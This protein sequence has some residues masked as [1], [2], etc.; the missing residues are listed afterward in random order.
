M[1]SILPVV[2]RAV[3]RRTDTQLKPHGYGKPSGVVI[4]D[5]S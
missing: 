1:P 4:S 2:R 3:P 5:A